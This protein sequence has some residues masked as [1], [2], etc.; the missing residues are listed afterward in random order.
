[1]SDD[2]LIIPIETP[3]AAEAAAV[4]GQV[5]AQVDGLGGSITRAAATFNQLHAAFTT[6]VGSVG[7]LA[8]RIG[9]ASEEQER[10][11]ALSARLGVNF[12]E[13]AAS[14]GRF[15]DE[16]EAMA[17]AG[18]FASA[19]I[20]VTQ[21]R[22][23]DLMRVAGAASITLGTDTAGAVQML[24]EALVRGREGGL[25]RF[26]TE[27][28]SVAGQSHTVE[29]RFAA[30]H[31]QALRVGQ[32][33]DTAAD[34]VKRFQDAIGD[35]A[36]TM[37]S[38]FTTELARLAAVQS[39]FASASSSAED[40]K[41]TLEAIGQTAALM[42]HAVVGGLQIIAGSVGTILGGIAEIAGR[43]PGLGSFGQAGRDFRLES[44]RLV[45]GAVSGLEAIGRDQGTS[46][47][48]AAPEVAPA[49]Q[50]GAGDTQRHGGAG[51]GAS[52]TE[53]DRLAQQQEA[54][55]AAAEEQ[56][57]AAA[58]DADFRAVLRLGTAED[59]LAQHRAENFNAYL[60]GEAANDNARQQEA[61]RATA[62]FNAQR[63]LANKDREL[64]A[65]RETAHRTFTG[66]LTELYAAQESAGTRLADATRSTFSDIGNAL[67]THIQAVVA[68]KETLG[69]ALRG[70]LSDTLGAIAKEAAM[71]GALYFAEGL[72][73]LITA[74]PLAA[75]DFGASA[76]FFGVAALAGAGAAATAPSS[77]PAAGGGAA[78]GGRAAPVTSTAGGSSAQGGGATVVNNYYAPQFGGRTGTMSEVG[79]HVM[80]FTNIEHAR[81]TRAA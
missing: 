7:A 3:G 72:G 65:E 2:A 6:V 12:D 30:L 4:L 49:G 59:Q 35:S 76:A 39:G 46:R 43:L 66:H 40:F 44:Q 79:Q 47:T 64:L 74:P 48:T 18:R 53:G 55:L 22:L 42:V 60:R 32:A 62:T 34:S 54:A 56:A 31:Q 71:K 37:A 45:S 5:G 24:Q 36:R 81:T 10:L 67:S 73:H 27:L 29:E 52:G 8:T 69:Q 28:A 11:N 33:H 51:H 61:Q 20:T 78:S 26:G 38:A 9:E 77:A 80:R 75:A 15:A 50:A 19:D 63:A 23:N 13:A 14:A 58:I 57:R 68:G 70:M 16:T 25:Q 21:Q 1:V 17:A 41:H